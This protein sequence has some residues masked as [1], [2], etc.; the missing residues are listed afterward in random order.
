M[1]SL[2]RCRVGGNR[3]IEFFALGMCVRT[4]VR[5][6]ARTHARTRAYVVGSRN[7]GTIVC[8][9]LNCRNTYLGRLIVNRAELSAAVPSR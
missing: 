5:T 7:R 2:A 6:H 8:P 3:V 1:G 4:H 9:C